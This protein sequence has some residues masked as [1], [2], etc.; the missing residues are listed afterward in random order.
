[1]SRPTH[2]TLPAKSNRARL[3]VG[4]RAFALALVLSVA[5]PIGT[6]F[7]QSCLSAAETRAAIASG[8]VMPLSSVAS[9]AR[10]R[11]YAQ[12]AS[13]NVC[14]AGGTL[15]YQVVAIASSGASARL[16]IHG[17]SGAVL[18]ER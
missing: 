5:P 16:T 10:S 2:N 9:I 17:V 4:F 14:S 3:P 13:A 7:T 12:V 18:A 1:M 15:V 11:G 6:G 8:Q